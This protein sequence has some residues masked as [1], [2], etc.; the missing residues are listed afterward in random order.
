MN[1]NPQLF[2]LFAYDVYPQA[3][4]ELAHYKDEF[5]KFRGRLETEMT[6]LRS[7]FE[8][9]VD[10]NEKMRSNLELEHAAVVDLQD[11]CRNRVSHL[12]NALIALCI[13]S[14]ISDLQCIIFLL[15]TFISWFGTNSNI[16]L[17]Y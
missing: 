1:I 15:V 8:S 3:N 9:V 12:Q 7:Q 11:E 17:F 14:F 4:T 6:S 2:F 10:E 16:L 13:I 5:A